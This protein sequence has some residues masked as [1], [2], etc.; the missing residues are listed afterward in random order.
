VEGQKTPLYSAHQ[1]LGAKMVPFC[2]FIM[3]VSYSSILE[4]HQAVRTAAGLFDLTHMGEFELFGPQAL[5]D[6]SRLVT[7][8]VLRLAV[9][10]AQYTPMCTDDG[11]I[12]DDLI[13]YRLGEQH[14]LLIVNAANIAKDRDWVKRHLSSQT[15][16]VDSSDETALLAL[17]GPL[18]PAILSRVFPGCE[19]LPSFG[20]VVTLYDGAQAILARTGYTGEDGFEIVVPNEKAPSLWKK[21]LVDPVKPIGLGARDT[22]RFE[23]KLLLY[24]N[25][26]DET[27]SPLEA[28]IAWTVKFDKGEFVGR[29]VLLAQK[30]KGLSRRLVG[31]KM[32]GRGIARHGHDVVLEGK[33]VGSV[34]S[35]T[36]SPTLKANL[37][38]AYVPTKLSTPGSELNI[39][40]RD[41]EVA[42]QVV[43]TPFYKR[44]VK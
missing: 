40:I 16:F 14:V 21:L 3:P 18:A 42:A 44:T 36:F 41:K 5:S 26:I 8:N 15:R 31:F 2:G 30:E 17:Q 27:T 22:L 32:Q 37:G 13:V 43:P 38:L 9:G 39:L 20:L 12:V 6:V 34:T 7:N 23:A 19:Q 25:D 33:K 24:G 1:E 29:Q 4:E 11:G 35:G 10:E 28:G